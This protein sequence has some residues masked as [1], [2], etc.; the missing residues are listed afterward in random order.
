MFKLTLKYTKHQ[1]FIYNMV[2]YTIHRERSKLEWSIFHFNVYNNP[3]RNLK[4]KTLQ[5]IS[6]KRS[7]NASQ[8]KPKQ[9]LE[10]FNQWLA[11][12]PSILNC[13]VLNSAIFDGQ[14]TRILTG[15]QNITK[16]RSSVHS[17][18]FLRQHKSNIYGF[19]TRNKTFDINETPQFFYCV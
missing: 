10:P 13:F 4:K 5:Y 6:Y 9:I 17:K 1:Q 7:L 18:P 15:Q 11:D 16:T 14:L 8:Y 19:L 3:I 2:N 12:K